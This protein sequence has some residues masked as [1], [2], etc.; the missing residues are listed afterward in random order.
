MNGILIAHNVVPG[1]RMKIHHTSHQPQS[2]AD[3]EDAI[4]GHTANFRR[5]VE[6]AGLS[7]VRGSPKFQAPVCRRSLR[8]RGVDD[9]RQAWHT[10]AAP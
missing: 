7:A 1:A 5:V 6:S 2:T 8:H 4:L 9:H 3:A 10:L